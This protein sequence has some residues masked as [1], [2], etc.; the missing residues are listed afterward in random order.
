M[1]LHP[2][3]LS[4]ASG[5]PQVTGTGQNST[6]ANLT[7]HTLTTNIPAGN[8]GDGIL[9]IFGSD[10]DPTHTIDTVVSG[11][12]W[13]TLA[14]NFN[15]TA[16]RGTVYFK[17]AEGSDALKI[18]TSAAENCSWIIKRLS[19]CSAAS[20][21]SSNG[22]GTDSNPPNHAPVA[23]SDDYLWFA[24]RVGDDVIAPTVAPTNYGNLLSQGSGTG[25][26]TVSTSD[27]E[28]TAASEDPGVFTVASEN[29]VTF[30]V[31]VAP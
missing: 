25:R 29:W 3:K 9:V 2:P 16:V 8:V 5:F 19:P 20:A 10:G 28:L 21:A 24:C 18:D 11:S 30:T 26:C 12:N 13:Q 6:G 31:A 7:S 17:I 27:R 14:S 15:L 22:N 1:L 4:A 23:G